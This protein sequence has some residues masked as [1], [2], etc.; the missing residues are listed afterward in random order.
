MAMVY[1][2]VIAV[3]VPPEEDIS[4]CGTWLLSSGFYQVNVRKGHNILVG[5]KTPL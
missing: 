3:N 5:L 1:C 4:A 2:A